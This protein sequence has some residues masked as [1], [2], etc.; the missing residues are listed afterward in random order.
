MTERIK[1]YISK[2]ELHMMANMRAEKLRETLLQKLRDGGVPIGLYGRLQSGTLTCDHCYRTGGRTYTWS[3]DNA[4]HRKT[5]A[6]GK[7]RAGET[8]ERRQTREETHEEGQE[9][10]G[11]PAF[12]T[13]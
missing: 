8:Q 12:R 3:P 6:R 7:S 4:Q 13:G 9:A 11:A 5:E 2:D 1:V 10:Q